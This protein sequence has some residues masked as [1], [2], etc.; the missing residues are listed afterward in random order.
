M[1]G[2]TVPTPDDPGV[3]AALLAEAHAQVLEVGRGR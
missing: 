1:P 2:P 3:L